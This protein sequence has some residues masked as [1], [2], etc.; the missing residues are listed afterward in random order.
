MMMFFL[1]KI[2]GTGSR[3]RTKKLLENGFSLEICIKKV[4]KRD[5]KY[6]VKIYRRNAV[7]L[8]IRF[9]FS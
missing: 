3:R 7:A 4:Y 2:K 5:K 9:F 1:V 6:E 8:T